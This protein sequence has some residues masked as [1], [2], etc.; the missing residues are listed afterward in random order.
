MQKLIPTISADI[1]TNE[2]VSKSIE[3]KSELF[4]IF[5]RLFNSLFV[6]ITL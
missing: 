6:M 2:V 3:I 1:G 5:M 4:R